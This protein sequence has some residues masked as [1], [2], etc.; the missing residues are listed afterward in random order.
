M[1]PLRTSAALAAVALGGCVAIE[2]LAPPVT[3]AMASRAGSSAAELEGG[4]RLY[5][6]RCASCHAID[7]VAKY[8]AARWQEIVADMADEAELTPAEKSELLAYVL[9]A[10][11]GAT[12]L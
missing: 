1:H 8:T 6:G 9:A 4:R 12:A 7:P 10:R 5:V 3:P 11:A 2:T